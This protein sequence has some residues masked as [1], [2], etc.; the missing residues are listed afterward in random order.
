MTELFIPVFFKLVDDHCQ[1]LGH[2]VGYTFHATLAVLDG[3]IGWQL[4][5]PREADIRTC[6]SLKQNWRSLSERML[7]GHPQRG[8]YRWMRMLAVPSAMNSATG[9]AYISVRRMKRLVESNM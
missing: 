4:F 8:I 7:C 6:K 2:R 9:V 3:R 5:E 1:H